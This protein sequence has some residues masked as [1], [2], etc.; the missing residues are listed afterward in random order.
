MCCKP[1]WIEACTTFYDYSA[2]TC[3]V[4]VNDVDRVD[5]TGD[6][7]CYEGWFTDSDDLK[8]ACNIDTTEYEFDETA[9]PVECT[10]VDTDI[11]PT[12]Y[13]KERIPVVVE[14]CCVYNGGD[15]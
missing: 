8:A 11:S 5:S 13:S 15:P 6:E 10:K 7:C 12:V 4:T 14:T 9:M 1:E 2:D 3:T